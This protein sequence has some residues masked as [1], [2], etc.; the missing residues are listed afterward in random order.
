MCLVKILAKLLKHNIL[1]RLS[2]FVAVI[3]R[4]SKKN[5][6]KI[7]FHCQDAGIETFFLNI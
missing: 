5:Y 2:V 7:F 6:C 4:A 1:H 3:I